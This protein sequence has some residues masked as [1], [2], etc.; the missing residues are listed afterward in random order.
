MGTAFGCLA[1]SSL[2]PLGIVLS[3]PQVYA[4]VG[5]A[6]MLAG[7]CRVP[8]T[9]VLLLFE[10]TRDYFII[11]VCWKPPRS[12]SPGIVTISSLPN[13]ALDCALSEP[14][15]AASAPCSW[16]ATICAGSD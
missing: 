2:Q 10:L 4:L 5:V 13:I 16:F 6:A 3:A 9:S 14:S 12:R 1:A 8:L 15:C 7:N 11:L